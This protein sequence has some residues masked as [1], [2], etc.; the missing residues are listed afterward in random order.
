MVAFKNL[1][2]STGKHLC[3]SF[4]LIKLQAG[5]QL[6]SFI[7][8]RLQQRC[9]PANIVKFLRRAF[10]KNASGDYVSTDNSA[11]VSL[12]WD[13]MVVNTTL[14]NTTHSQKFRNTNKL[15]ICDYNKY[16]AVTT[17]P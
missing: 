7:E 1:A 6:C 11:C 13:Y 8:K 3:W 2:N 12:R 10:L 5:L 4:F 16:Y 9:F 14:S 17:Q 15:I